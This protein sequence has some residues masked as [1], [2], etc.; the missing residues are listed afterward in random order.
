MA[1]R[2]ALLKSFMAMM[3][4]ATTGCLSDLSARGGGPAVVIEPGTPVDH[5]A[6]KPPKVNKP[7]AGEVLIAGGVNSKLKS[8]AHAEF[9]NP[10]TKKFVVASPLKED[11]VATVGIESGGKV[12]IFSGINGSA[13]LSRTKGQLRVLANVRDDAEVYDPA[14]GLFSIAANKPVTGVAFYTATPL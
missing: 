13:T 12:T 9:Y 4:I 11:R 5:V 6:A 10:T 7:V 1:Y 14:T 2:N 3:L 8:D